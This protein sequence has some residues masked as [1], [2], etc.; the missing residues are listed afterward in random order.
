MGDVTAPTLAV[1]DVMPTLEEV[2]SPFDPTEL[3]IVAT[4]VADEIHVAAVV[5]FWV[6]PSVYVP[7]ALNCF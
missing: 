4:G 5:R 6:V 3:L 1:M 2:A 7:V